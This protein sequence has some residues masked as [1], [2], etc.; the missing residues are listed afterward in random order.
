MSELTAKST[1]EAVIQA[2]TEKLLT[3]EYKHRVCKMVL[4]D[5]VIN[6][7]GVPELPQLLVDQLKTSLIIQD[8][9]KEE[10]NR[11]NDHKKHVETD[12]EVRHPLL[13]RIRPWLKRRLAA[14]HQSFMEAH[15]WSAH[16]AAIEACQVWKVVLN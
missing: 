2:T 10:A 11:L 5:P 4:A 1:P 8:V 12:L 13:S 15:L 3:S 9:L 16:A 14:A 7:L 6:S